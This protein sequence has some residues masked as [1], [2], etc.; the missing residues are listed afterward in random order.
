MDAAEGIQRQSS[1]QSKINILIEIYGIGSL[2]KISYHQLAGAAKGNITASI[3]IPQ[4]TPQLTER[5]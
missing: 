5:K 1:T 4:G 3:P 2:S